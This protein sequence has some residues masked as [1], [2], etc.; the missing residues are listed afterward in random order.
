MTEPL[1]P[2]KPCP[3][4]GSKVRLDYFD[5]VGHP[6]YVVCEECHALGPS[7]LGNSGACEAWNTHPIEAQLLEACKHLVTWAAKGI[8]AT[9]DE[10]E[11]IIDEATA[12]IAAAEGGEK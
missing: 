3:F 12:A 5:A 7:D 4:C 10:M 2:L 11:I 8:D 9:D 1:I 6:Y